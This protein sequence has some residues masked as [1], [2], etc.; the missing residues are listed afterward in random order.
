MT[1]EQ[2]E[3]WPVQVVRGRSYGVTFYLDW[4]AELWTARAQIRA[5]ADPG[6]ALLAEFVVT[7]SGYK[8]Q[9]AGDDDSQ[10]MGTPVTIELIPGQ[11]SGITPDTG[12]WDLSM[13]DE[14][15]ITDTYICGPVSILDYP[16]TW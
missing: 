15:G 11:T 10:Y 9:D 14:E 7:I 16:T 13:I 5:S 8:W 4:D 6:S 2:A 3:F 1:V 12:F